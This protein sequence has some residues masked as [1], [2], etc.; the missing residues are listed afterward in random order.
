MPAV[1]VGGHPKDYPVD[2]VCHFR[3]KLT[4]RIRCKWRNHHFGL[5]GHR[6]PGTSCGSFLYVMAA[7]ADYYEVVAFHAL[8]SVS[9]LADWPVGATETDGIPSTDFTGHCKGSI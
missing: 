7:F 6:I 1:M 9:E 3:C 2:P 4:S 5:A 8:E